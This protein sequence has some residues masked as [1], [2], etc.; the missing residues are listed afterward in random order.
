MVLQP[1]EVVPVYEVSGKTAELPENEEETGVEVQESLPLPSFVGVRWV[2]DSDCDQCTACGSPFT[3]VR[4][5]HHC[6]NC[7]RIFCGKCS[8][9]QLSI[10]ELGYD[11]KVRV[12]NL[13]F[14]YKVN[15]F[16]PPYGQQ[17]QFQHEQHQDSEDYPQ[18]SHLL[19]N[20]SSSPSSSSSLTSFPSTRHAG[21][22]LLTTIANINMSS[23]APPSSSGNANNEGGDGDT[24]PQYSSS[25]SNHN[26]FLLTDQEHAASSSSFASV[27]SN[28]YGS[29]T[30]SAAAS[31]SARQAPQGIPL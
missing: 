29:A 19:T 16:Q 4:R 14:L 7:G 22:Q 28:A 12:C 5:R 15:P 1:V 21:T 10:P 26:P 6:R 2:P 30:M 9:N 3:M 31:G 11:K 17:Q 20:P 18:S 23:S 27:N 25:A 24:F 13:C 8:T